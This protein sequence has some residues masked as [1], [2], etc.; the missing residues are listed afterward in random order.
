MPFISIIFIA[1]GKSFGGPTVF[2]LLEEG[3]N[4]FENLLDDF[5]GAHLG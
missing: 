1:D 3:F 2:I 5:R 4:G